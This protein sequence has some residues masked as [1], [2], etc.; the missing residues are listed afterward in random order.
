[1]H[2]NL[3]RCSCLAL[4]V[5]VAPILQSQTLPADQAT[6]PDKKELML[7]ASRL[8]NLTTPDMK[9][10]HI[11]AT[12]QTFDETGAVSDE[13]TFEE[14]WAGP[15]KF[16][17]VLTGKTFTETEY[18]TEQGDFR[19]PSPPGGMFLLARLRNDL[20]HP[21]PDE[22]VVQ[23][24]SYSSGELETGS[25]KLTCVTQSFPY[26]PSYCLAKSEPFLRIYEEPANSIRAFYNRLLRFQG[27]VVAGDRKQTRNGKDDLT[28]HLDTIESVDPADQSVFV[29]PPGANIVPIPRI[30]NISAGVA[31]GMIEHKVAPEY[32]GY[33]KAERISGTVVLQARIDK[34]GH[35]ADLSVVSGPEDLRSAA[36]EAVRQWRYRPYLLNGE[37]VEV[38]TTI[39]VIFSLGG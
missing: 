39:N 23:R 11:K 1:M 8:N 30:V 22:K 6:P 20:T 25:L 3:F 29:A 38:R 13:G 28:V 14:W 9:P 7:A 17:S 31:A 5:F 37:P 35:I 19:V 15:Q 16:K 34:T 26:A 21:L 10:W 2:H 27:K 12:Y 24:A 33:A 18:I 36:A 32:P 4:V